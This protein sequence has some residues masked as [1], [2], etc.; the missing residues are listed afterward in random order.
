[1]LRARSIFTSQDFS[2]LQK[3]QVN[4]VSRVP[5][6]F[7]LGGGFLLDFLRPMAAGGE[8]C[9]AEEDKGQKLEEVVTLYSVLWMQ[10]GGHQQWPRREEDVHHDT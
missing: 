8:T 9:G 5:V 3:G 4:W 1:M 2:W 6:I 7:F 10:A